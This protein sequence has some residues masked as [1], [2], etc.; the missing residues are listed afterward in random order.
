M[1]TRD[2]HDWSAV[3]AA[4]G[5]ADRAAAEEGIRLAYRTAGLAEPERI[6]W[7]ASPRAAVEAVEKN[8]AGRLDREDGP[9]LVYPDGFAL[10]AWR[11][12][13][14]PAEFPDELTGLSRARIRDEENAGLRRAM[15]EHY[16]YERYLTESGAEPVHRGETGILWRI[17]LPFDEDVV[18]VEA[19]DSTPGPDGAHRTSW[20]RVPPTTRTAKEGAARTFGPGPDPGPGTSPR[21]S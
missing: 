21:A 11:G 5:P 6:V 13:P 3:A 14:V 18:V 2:V 15:L 4:T 16:G 10:H 20:L 8:E 9:A 1:K 12:I 19:V 17:T 7:A